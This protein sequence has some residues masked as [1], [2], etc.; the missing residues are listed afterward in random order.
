MQQQQWMRDRD[1][2]VQ[3]TLAFAAKVAVK[4]VRV[5]TA[6]Q[7]ESPKASEFTLVAR[8]GDKV[9]DREEMRQRVADFSNSREGNDGFDGSRHGTP[10]LHAM[11][12]LCRRDATQSR[13]ESNPN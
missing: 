4:S 10:Q 11:H 12:K 7:I 2:L 6:A 5:E 1:L 3:E 13:E 9:F 8:P